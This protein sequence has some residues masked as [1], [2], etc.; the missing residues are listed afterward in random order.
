MFFLLI[1]EIL[2]EAVHTKCLYRLWD[3]KLNWN[4][5]MDSWAAYHV[6]DVDQRHHIM[7]LHFSR[8]I[9]HLYLSITSFS[10]CLLLISFI[11]IQK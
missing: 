6:Q 10:I 2:V 9:H 11:K 5:I 3:G 7:P 4:H 8:Y 1:A